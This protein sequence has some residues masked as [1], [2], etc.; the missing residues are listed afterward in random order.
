[1]RASLTVTSRHMGRRGRPQGDNTLGERTQSFPCIIRCETGS[2]CRNIVTEDSCEQYMFSVILYMLRQTVGY[3]APPLPF[4]YFS[5]LTV[6]FRK[7]SVILRH[8][9]VHAVDGHPERACDSHRCHTSI[10]CTLHSISLQRPGYRSLFFN[11]C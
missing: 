11:A 5:P 3:R 9:T 7:L 2:G 1:V 6:M 4:P 10:Q 8:Y